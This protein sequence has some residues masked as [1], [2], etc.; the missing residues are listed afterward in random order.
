MTKWRG[1][2]S[3]RSREIAELQADPELAAEYLKAAMAALD[4]AN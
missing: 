4:S 3:Q 2:A 1:L